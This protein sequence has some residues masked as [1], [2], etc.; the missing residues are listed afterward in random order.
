[1]PKRNNEKRTELESLFAFQVKALSFP[2]PVREYRFHDTRKFRFDFA[3][4]DFKFAFEA[5]GGE[6]INGAHNR[7]KGM[8]NDY[9]KMS[10]ALLLGW[11]VYRAT[12]TM[13]KKGHAINF[14]ERYFKLKGFI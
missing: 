7:G 14:V 11:D 1:M 4:P 3:W 8:A 5:D 12:G 10:E 6:W 9:E 2:E 13:I